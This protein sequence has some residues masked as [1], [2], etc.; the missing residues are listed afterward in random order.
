MRD[1]FAREKEI[2]SSRNVETSRNTRNCN[3]RK[4][5]IDDEIPCCTVFGRVCKQVCTSII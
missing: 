3:C 1:P 4:M 5:S 2:A